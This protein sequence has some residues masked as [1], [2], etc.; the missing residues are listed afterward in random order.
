MIMES[1]EIYES[2]LKQSGAICIDTMEELFDYAVAL[3]KQPIPIDGDLVIISNGGG[4]AIIVTDE[5]SKCE[6]RTADINEIR[7][8]IDAVIPQ[9]E[10]LK[11]LL[12]YWEML[13][14]I[15]SRMY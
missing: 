9:R 6:I 2:L 5:C 7:E 14:T 3:S 15:D 13:I 11:I 8:K 10:V 1:D 4:H 12:I